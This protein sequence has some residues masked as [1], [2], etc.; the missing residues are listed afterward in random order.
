MI[1]FRNQ[2]FF[3][4]YFS[5]G[6]KQRAST[7]LDFEH[8]FRYSVFSL[9]IAQFN[10]VCSYIF[11]CVTFQPSDFLFC[12]KLAAS[13]S[14]HPFFCP[15]VASNFFYSSLDECLTNLWTLPTFSKLANMTRED[16]NS[17]VTA[18]ATAQVKLCPYDEEEPHI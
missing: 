6:S 5:V 14:V 3:Q 8:V 4:I 16:L 1:S 11:M 9:F 10:P 12:S 17:P 2:Q 18:A 7:T 15:T 13:S